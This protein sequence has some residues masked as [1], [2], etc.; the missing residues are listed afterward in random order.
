MKIRLEAVPLFLCSF[1]FAGFQAH[2]AEVKGNLN[3][4]VGQKLLPE[5]DWKEEGFG[6]WSKQ[7]EAG[8]MFDI[9]GKSWPVN[10][11]VDLLGSKKT[12]TFDGIDIDGK[13]SE[14]ALGVRKYFM[15]A[16]PL[17]PYFGAGLANIKG[18]IAIGDNSASDTKIGPWADAGVKLNPI[19]W[20][21]IGA[22]VR[23][24][25]AKTEVNNVKFQSGGWH[26]GIFAGWSFE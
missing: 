7:T 5:S 23:Y 17:K 18:E 3:L 14:F 26:W 22:D 8:I 1:I 4:I 20:L 19:Q 13:T 9:G 10:I 15:D 24:S 21:N 11:A 2:A 12:V 16:Q 25:Y 6:D